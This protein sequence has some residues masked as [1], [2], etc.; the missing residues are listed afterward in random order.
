[1]IN[2]RS[3]ITGLISFVAAPAIVQASN[4]MPVKMMSFNVVKMVGP[5]EWDPKIIRLLRPDGV[6]RSFSKEEMAR[7][8]VRKWLRCPSEAIFVDF[9]DSPHRAVWQS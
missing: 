3:I 7:N 2:R 6:E 1:M 8:E 9:A 5:L 4:L